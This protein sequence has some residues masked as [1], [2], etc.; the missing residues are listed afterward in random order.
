MFGASRWR[1]LKLL[2]GDLGS[3]CWAERRSLEGVDIQP[4]FA[5]Y[6]FRD[7]ELRRVAEKGNVGALWRKERIRFKDLMLIP[8]NSISGSLSITAEEPPAT[9]WRSGV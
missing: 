1:Q 4:D 9:L 2:E 6:E 5:G 7:M 3:W 8:G